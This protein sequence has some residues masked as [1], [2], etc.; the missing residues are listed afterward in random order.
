MIEC[1]QEGQLLCLSQLTSTTCGQRRC[2]RVGSSKG[3]FLGNRPIKKLAS[4]RS[5]Q[6]LEWDGRILA[7]DLYFSYIGISLGGFL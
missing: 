2:E 4:K 6:R 5:F 3:A 1:S 7:W